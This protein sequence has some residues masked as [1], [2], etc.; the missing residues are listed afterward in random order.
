VYQTPSSVYPAN[1]SVTWHPDPFRSG[2]ESRAP[3]YGF[4]Q[5]PRP[6]SFPALG[7]QTRSLLDGYRELHSRGGGG[8]GERSG[9][10]LDLSQGAAG[11]SK[12]TCMRRVLCVSFVCASRSLEPAMISN[13]SQIGLELIEMAGK[14]DAKLQLLLHP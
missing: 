10:P 8:G 7:S 5:R 3:L 4:T 12:H 6:V 1:T 9:S 11:S 14:R 2:T 13:R